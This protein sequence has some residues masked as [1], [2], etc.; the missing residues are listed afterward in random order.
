[1]KFNKRPK[2]CTTILSKELESLKKSILEALR[3]GSDLIEIRLDFMTHIDLRMICNTLSEFIDKCIFTMR[4][5]SEGGYFNGDEKERLRIL[6]ELSLLKPAY[7]DLELSTIKRKDDYSL[8]ILN[9]GTNIIVSWH[10]FEKTPSKNE[11]L[12]I[13]QEAS[14]YSNYIKIVTMASNFSD[15]IKIL[16]LYREVKDKKLIAFC[17]GEKGIISRILCPYLGSPFTYASFN[18]PAAPSQLNLVDMLDL[19]AIL[20]LED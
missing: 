14:S 11:L 7:L 19:Y 3:L 10:D 1:M 9:S 15:N 2:I 13:I 12:K 20:K 17:M 8:H 16:S 6:W 5:K 4:C 18:L